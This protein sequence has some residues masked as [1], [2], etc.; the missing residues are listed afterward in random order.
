MSIDTLTQ[1]ILDARWPSLAQYGSILGRDEAVIIADHLTT[2]GYVQ[3]YTVTELNEVQALP[4]GS[5]VRDSHSII[6]EL[7]DHQRDRDWWYRTGSDVSDYATEMVFPVR[8][9]YHPEGK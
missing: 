7:E 1:D 8:V 9:L 2:R 3:Q 5:V 6:R 4:V